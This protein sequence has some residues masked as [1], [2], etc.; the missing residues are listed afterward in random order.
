[1]P[2]A[3]KLTGLTDPFPVIHLRV[4]KHDGDSSDNIPGHKILKLNG[5]WLPGRRGTGIP[6]A[7]SALCAATQESFKQDSE[8]GEQQDLCSTATLINANS[9]PRLEDGPGILTPL[10]KSKV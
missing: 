3:R 10:G 2:A 6:G 1:M 7:D 8:W 5:A 4:T 9:W